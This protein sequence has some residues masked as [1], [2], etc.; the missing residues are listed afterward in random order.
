MI[1]L[2]G[3][4]L[5]KQ[6]AVLPPESALPLSL[7]G[8]QVLIHGNPTP[9]IKVDPGAIRLQLP[10]ELPTGVHYMQVSPPFNSPFAPAAQLMF[11]ALALDPHFLAGDLYDEPGRFSTL[12]IH[13]DWSPV[14]SASPAQEGEILHFFAT[15]FGTVNG[16]VVT[17]VP[18]PSNPLF[19]VQNAVNLGPRSPTDVT[20]DCYS[21]ETIALDL[22]FA[23]LAPGTVGI[24]QLDM[25]LSH[26]DPAQSS[27]TLYC[28][29]PSGLVRSPT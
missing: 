25:Q 19:P 3:I 15:G 20:T 29:V 10:W 26:L 16:P 23:G 18:A 27:V 7:G 14:T 24:Y 17:G 21:N 28:Q 12:A 6:S 22:L 2:T 5:A 8:V 13:E 1:V 9:L 4:A 11:Q